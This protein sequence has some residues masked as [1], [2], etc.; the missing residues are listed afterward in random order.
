MLRIERRI[1]NQ[2]CSKSCKMQN[3]AKYIFFLKIR[4]N[5]SFLESHQSDGMIPCS[6]LRSPKVIIVLAGP[7]NQD[8]RKVIPY[9]VS[10][11]SC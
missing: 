5:W 7:D 2:V 3:F 9:K 11:F 8:L 4:S 1:E 6:I 10:L